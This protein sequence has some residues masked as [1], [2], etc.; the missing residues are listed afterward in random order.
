M[1]R[2]VV[3][4]LIALQALLPPGMCLCQVTPF[5]P[6]TRQAAAPLRVA[7]RAAE[8]EE[9]CS[10][11]ACRKARPAVAPQAAR[12]AIPSDLAAP[13]DHHTP[14]PAP[15]CSGCP[16]VSAGPLARTAILPA[17]EQAPPPASVH[18]VVPTEPAAP[19][20]AAVA[21]PAFTSP[22]PPLFVRHCAYLI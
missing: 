9:C 4:L 14:A 10:C 8:D 3:A 21:T 22:S 12:D 13:H 2:A 5:E 6:T 20:I 11:P 15:P 19:D 1:T 7:A 16:I 18:F 17:P